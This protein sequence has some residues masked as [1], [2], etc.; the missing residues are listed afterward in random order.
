MKFLVDAQLPQK[1]SDFLCSLGEDSIHTLSLPD[2]NATQD[3]YLRTI[4]TNEMRVIITKDSDFLDSHILSKIPPKLILVT[5]GNIMNTRL[6]EIFRN[7]WNIIIDSLET[8]D[9]IEISQ[10]EIILH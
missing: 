1:L 6:I 8:H 3:G 4:S 9:F 10:N 2:K 5:T 7:N